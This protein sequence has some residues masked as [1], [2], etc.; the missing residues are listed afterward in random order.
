MVKSTKAKAT[1]KKTDLVAK[2]SFQDIVIF[3]DGACSGN[4]G[5]GGWGAIIAYPEGRVVELGGGL[6]ATTNNQM[7]LQAVT[8]ALRLIGPVEQNILIYTDSV[9]V[10]R[11]ITE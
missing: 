2:A 8:E 7:E 11:G 5:R 1:R 9:Y 6:A 3:G 4:P 10:I